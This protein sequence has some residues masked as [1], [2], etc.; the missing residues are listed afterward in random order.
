MVCNGSNNDGIG[1]MVVCNKYVLLVFKQHG[2][3]VTGE[4]SVGGSIDLVGK[5]GQAEDMVYIIDFVC[6]EEIFHDRGWDMFDFC[7]WW[8]GHV[9]WCWKCDGRLLGVGESDAGRSFLYMAFGGGCGWKEI[10]ADSICS[11]ARP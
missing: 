5:C 8:N 9:Q 10:L 2:G 7:F 4:V 11:K 1:C 3:K 6:Q